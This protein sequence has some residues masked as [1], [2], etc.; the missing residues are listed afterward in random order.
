[1]RYYETMR[2]MVWTTSGIERNRPTN[3]KEKEAAST[4]KNEAPLQDYSELKSC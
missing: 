4:H 1:M 3:K 2:V